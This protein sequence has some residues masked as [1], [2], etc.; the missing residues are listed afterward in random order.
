MKRKFFWNFLILIVLLLLA[1]WASNFP[2]RTPSV[3]IIAITL[4]VAA[5]LVTVSL[6]WIT[7]KFNDWFSTSHQVSKGILDSISSEISFIE[8]S[9]LD[10]G[11][12]KYSYEHAIFSPKTM[13]KVEKYINRFSKKYKDIVVDKIT[14]TEAALIILFAGYHKAVINLLETKFVNSSL[15]EFTRLA[16]KAGSNIEFQK[17]VLTLALG[18]Y[19]SGNAANIVKQ[20]YESQ[21]KIYLGDWIP[22]SR[23]NFEKAVLYAD[24]DEILVT[25]HIGNAYKPF[26]IFSKLDKSMKKID[27]YF[28]HPC[29]LSRQGLIELSDELDASSILKREVNF[30]STKDGN[31][32]IDY[33]RKVLQLLSNIHEINEFSCQAK[34]QNIRLFFYAQKI[35]SVCVQIVKNFGYLFLI[36]A[37]FDNAKFLSRFTVEVKDKKITEM[38][39]KIVDADL[40]I[41]QDYLNNTNNQNINKD[42]Q[43]RYG[44][45]I[46]QFIFT[47]EY[48]E[49]LCSESLSELA[50]YLTSNN[51]SKQG[52][53]EAESELMIRL[54]SDIAFIKKHYKMLLD[55]MPSK[56]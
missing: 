10:T 17:I 44:G 43:N 19:F 21:H 50:V 42:I 41:R 22:H 14:S 45:K 11:R 5:N 29:I 33:V 24:D 46:E 2:V 53:I 39:S 3:I 31:F 48:F 23:A 1:L 35:P 40:L 7:G 4:G 32:Q 52:L 54:P 12:F 15:P 36:P 30:L 38:F 28:I 49:S 47:Q 51:I 20:I 8:V 13:A 16:E 26:D 34:N 25:Y 37:A 6:G 56:S 27:F 18:Q 55:L 9:Q